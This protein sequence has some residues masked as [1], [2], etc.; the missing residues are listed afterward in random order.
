MKIDPDSVPATV[1]AAVDAVVDALSD[2]ERHLISMAMTPAVVHHTAGRFIRNSWSLWSPDS[3]IKRNAVERYKIAHADD[4][5]G[6][7]FEWVWAKVRGTPFDPLEH[8]EGYHLHW[9]RTTGKT[10]LEAGGWPPTEE[11]G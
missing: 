11:T 2:S 3:P 4:I 8:V 1:E 6:L 9:L 7:I 5:S 10:S